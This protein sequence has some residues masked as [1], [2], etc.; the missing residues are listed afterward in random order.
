MIKSRYIV[1]FIFCFFLAIFASYQIGEKG[2]ENDLKKVGEYEL[3]SLE[4]G[5]VLL[6]ENDAV[7]SISGVNKDSVTI[8]MET[9]E[10]EVKYFTYSSDQKEKVKLNESNTQI[11][12]KSV[13][14]SYNVVK[15][16]VGKDS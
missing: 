13:L 9:K 6:E 11:L 14:P 4:T 7:Y 8:Q 16:Y 1:L 15:L 3:I 2:L 5:E 12:V 10:G